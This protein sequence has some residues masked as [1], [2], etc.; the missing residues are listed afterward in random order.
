M[1]RA[2]LTADVV[3]DVDADVDVVAAG[4]ADVTTLYHPFPR[5]RAKPG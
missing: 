3:A 5:P 1:I 2:A 4:A